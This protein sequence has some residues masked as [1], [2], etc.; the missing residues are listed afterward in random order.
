VKKCIDVYHHI[1]DN[2]DQ[3][4][5]SPEC[6]EIRKHMEACPDC[7]AYLDSLKKT[8]VLY[9][10]LPAP[11]ISRSAHARLFK[12]INLNNPSHSILK[13]RTRKLSRRGR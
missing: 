8:V 11:H 12:I 10:S 4:F 5:D 7:R 2:L 3:K 1:C 13:R 9:R 6:R